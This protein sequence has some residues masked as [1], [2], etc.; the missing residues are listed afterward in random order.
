[1]HT[2]SY[3]KAHGIRSMYECVNPLFLLFVIA[4]KDVENSS[5]RRRTRWV[6][7]GPNYVQQ[8]FWESRQQYQGFWLRYILL[9]IDVK[10]FGK[11]SQCGTLHFIKVPQFVAGCIR[12]SANDD[13]GKRSRRAFFFSE[14]LSNAF[15]VTKKQKRIRLL[16]TMD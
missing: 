16:K 4:W 10:L 11:E 9:H 8:A 12:L 3:R 14:V 15:V 5:G 2:Q 6:S 13:W 7:Q 1:M